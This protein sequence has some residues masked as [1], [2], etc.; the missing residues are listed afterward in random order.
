MLELNFEPFPTIITERLLLR[1]MLA[2]DISQFFAIRSNKEVMER[3]NK[4]RF[5]TLDEAK[6]L[7]NKIANDI[8]MGNGIMWSLCLKEDGRQIGNLSF[9]KIYKDHHRAELGYAL[10]PEFHMRGIMY[11]AVKAVIH[12]G[13]NN[14]KLH[15]I[16]AMINPANTASK[17]ILEKNGFKQEGLLKESFLFRTKFFDTAVY[18]LLNPN[19]SH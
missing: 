15:T 11:E 7:M 12:Y 6:S 2:T 4:E 18:S 3:I 14:M 10:L 13:F 1:E 17:R 19:T 9:H 5:K 16:E 8:K